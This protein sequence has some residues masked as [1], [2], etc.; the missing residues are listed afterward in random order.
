M[1][2]PGDVIKCDSSHAPYPKWHL[3]VSEEN[4]FIYLNSPKNKAYAGDFA[5]DASE[6]PFIPAHPTGQSIISCRNVMRKSRSEL[7]ASGAT[8]E[9]RFSENV[10]ESLLLFVDGNPVLAEDDQKIIL[11]G[12]GDWVG[13]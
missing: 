3:C 12:L 11:D 1:F 13:I 4:H 7:I 9:G 10:L 2:R 8:L 5:I 6:V